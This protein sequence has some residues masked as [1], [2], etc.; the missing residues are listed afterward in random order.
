MSFSRPIQL[1]DRLLGSGK[2]PLICTPL[3]GTQ[4]ADLRREMAVVIAKKPDLIEWRVDF[5][6]GIADLDRVLALG[7]EIHTLAAGIPFLFTRR[8]TREGGNPIPLDEDQVLATCAAICRAGLAEL[9]DVEL[10]VAPHHFAQAVALA[11]ETGARLVASYHNFQETPSAAEIVAKLVA[12]EKA[13]A[14]VVK[15]A[16]MPQDLRDVLTLLDATQQA[17]QDVGVPVISMS[18]GGYGALSRLFGWTFGSSVTFAIGE[19]SSAPGQVPID[20]INAVTTI[21]QRAFKGG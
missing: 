2:E 10:S 9:F 17:I 15:I 12:M 11:R 7:K 6:A 3:V 1:K 21:L 13:G 4:E 8:S 20:D 14:D 16:V 18:M 19:N 5:F